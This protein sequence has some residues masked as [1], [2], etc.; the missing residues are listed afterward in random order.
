[1]LSIAALVSYWR[2][3]VYINGEFVPDFDGIPFSDPRWYVSSPNMRKIE[4]HACSNYLAQNKRSN[5]S[6]CYWINVGSLICGFLGN[7][8]LLLNFTQRI[9]YLIALPATIILWYLATG[10][11]SSPPVSS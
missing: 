8:F 11:V 4:G 10:F 2:S 7:F 1:V 3:T 6:R 5:D 9:R